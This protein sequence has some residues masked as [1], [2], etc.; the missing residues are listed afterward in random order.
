MRYCIMTTAQLF[1]AVNLHLQGK[2]DDEAFLKAVIATEGVYEPL[3]AQDEAVEELID[4]SS[5]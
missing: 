2:G 4:N 3:S 5:A 1:E